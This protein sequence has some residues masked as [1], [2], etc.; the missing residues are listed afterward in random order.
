MKLKEIL[1]KVDYKLYGETDDIDIHELQ[2]NSSRVEKGDMFF[3]LKGGEF[4]GHDYAVDAVLAGAKVVVSDHKLSLPKMI[5]NVV[6]KN[7]RSTMAECA[8]NFYKNPAKDMKIVSITGTNGKTT[9]T[10]MIDSI[11][12]SAGLKSGIIGTNGVII[13]NDKF[14]TN[15]TTPDPIELQRILKIM[16]E[17]QVDVVV[18]EMS[19]HALELQ[20]NRGLMSDIGVF[21][22]LTQD[23]LDYFS[24]MEKYGK[25]KK[26]LFNKSACKF[27]VL[28]MDDGFAYEIL[29]DINITYATVGI[30]DGFDFSGSNIKHEN[31]G[32]KFTVCHDDREFDIKINMDGKFNISNALGAIAVAKRLGVSDEKIK[33]GLENLKGVPGRFNTYVIGS[34]KFIVDYAHTPDGIA[35]ILCASRQI[36]K[37]GNKLISIFGCGGNRDKTKRPIMGALST[38]LAD[39][40]IITSDNPRLENP[41]DIIHDI[42]EGV[43]KDKEYY[44]EPDRKKAI[45]LGFKLANDGDIIVVSGKGAEDYIDKGGVKT[46]YC[47][48]EVIEEIKEK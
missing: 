44:I 7:T 35:N 24:S 20:K 33:Q 3:C 10:Y 37:K 9:T 2:H 16:K 12:R 48:S 19:A 13:G 47:D 29:K 23:H 40:S 38:E 17:K 36:L 14:E 41:M 8:A 15:M 28:N 27:A 31:I 6:V 1:N 11:L 21:T 43:H 4:D 30:G 32:Q 45:K 26:K 46:H 22:N 18:M 42:E 34:K 5:T 39:I 25:A